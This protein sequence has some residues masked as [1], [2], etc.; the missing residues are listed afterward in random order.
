MEIDFRPPTAEDIIE[1]VADLSF[2]DRREVQ[3]LGLD[4]LWAISNSVKSSSECV[5]IIK[6]GKCVCITGL[7]E[8]DGIA[9][10]IYPWLM[11]TPSIQAHPRQVLKYSKMLINRWRAQHPYMFNYVDARHHRAI[12]WLT[13][14]GADFEFI[15]KHGVFNKPFY[16]FSFGSE[17]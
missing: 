11:A 12:V 1:L 5:A 14:L 15:P 4:P 13:H 9:Q 3:A 16:K 6:D 17:T 10:Q 8:S 2:E 7:Y